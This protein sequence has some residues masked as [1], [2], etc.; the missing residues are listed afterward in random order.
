MEYGATR[1]EQCLDEMNKTGDPAR[2]DLMD[3]F[4]AG[5]ETGLNLATDESRRQSLLRGTS[6][7]RE[8]V[9]ITRRADEQLRANTSTATKEARDEGR[10]D[11]DAAAD[12]Q[13]GARRQGQAADG[14]KDSADRAGAAGRAEK[15]TLRARLEVLQAQDVLFRAV[16]NALSPAQGRAG[17]GRAYADCLRAIADKIES[18]SSLPAV[19]VTG[20]PFYPTRDSPN[21]E[22]YAFETVQKYEE[23]APFLW[24]RFNGS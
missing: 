10:R 11:L 17:V 20:L 3:A 21:V 22:V 6:G 2:Y 24:K 14:G 7:I 19:L 16:S 4:W 15:G 23:T 5:V 13:M 18:G 12:G 9:G 8:L 1:L